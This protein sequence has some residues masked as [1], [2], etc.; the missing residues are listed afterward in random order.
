MYDTLMETSTLVLTALA[1]LNED[2]LNDDAFA[3]YSGEHDEVQRLLTELYDL[4]Y[5]H[6]DPLPTAALLV[7]A[8]Y[9]QFYADQEAA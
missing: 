7:D 2:L 8:W 6:G 9:E 5:A 4:V 3:G 1:A